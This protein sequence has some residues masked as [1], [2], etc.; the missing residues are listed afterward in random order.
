MGLRVA[1]Q[2]LK[3]LLQ[4]LNKETGDGLLALSGI[5]V[6]TRDKLLAQRSKAADKGRSLRFS[7]V[8]EVEGIGASKLAAMTEEPATGDIIKY[9]TYYTNLFGN[10]VNAVWLNLQ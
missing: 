8:M 7:D 10:E 3:D 4:V 9:A 2:K 1:H 6:V 5:G